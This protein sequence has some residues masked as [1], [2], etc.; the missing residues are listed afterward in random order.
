MS[1]RGKGPL[2]VNDWYQWPSEQRYAELSGVTKCSSSTLIDGSAEEVKNDL[3][4]KLEQYGNIDDIAHEIVGAWCYAHDKMG[5]TKSSGSDWCYWFYYWLGS[6]VFQES[7]EIRFVDFMEKVYN[8]LEKL[9]FGQKC[10][11]ISN[12]IDKRTFEQMRKMYEYYKDY[13]TIQTQLGGSGNKCDEKY[14]QHVDDILK[15]YN[16]AQNK[17]RGPTYSKHC[18]GFPN[19][20]S[21]PKYKA[22][23]DE[24]REVVTVSESM[25]ELSVPSTANTALSTVA[26]VPSTI[27]TLGIGLPFITYLLYKYNLLHSWFGNQFGSSRNNRR[28]R[29]IG[30]DFNTL[31]DTSTDATSTLYSTEASTIADSVETSRTYDN[32]SPR[33]R[34][35]NNGRGQQ[36]P[37]QQRQRKEKQQ[38]QQRQQNSRNIEARDV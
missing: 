1:G 14:D 28:R 15:A 27:A 13:S 5:V 32:S 38:Q 2:T 34:T 17:C 24:P 25:E 37:Q 8:A 19:M 36:Q 33:R 16:A 10:E 20:F 26:I 21:E 3:K 12:Y 7:G 6:T 23:L 30:H 31:T 11:A 9:K 4:D 29:T 35:T 18:N 22:L